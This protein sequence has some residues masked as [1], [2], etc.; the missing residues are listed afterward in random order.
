[1]HQRANSLASK[2]LRVF[3]CLSL[4]IAGW[5]EDTISHQL[6][7]SSDAVKFYVR[8]STFQTDSVGASLFKSA[9]VL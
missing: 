8:Q 1:M 9:L 2:S 5:D 6:R 3:A 4:K 7:W